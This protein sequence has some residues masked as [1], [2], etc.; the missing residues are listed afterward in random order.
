MVA[1]RVLW[2]LLVRPVGRLVIG[3]WWCIDALYQI[4]ICIALLPLEEC[5]VFYSLVVVRV[6]F[7]ESEVGMERMECCNPAT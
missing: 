2:I 5:R 3:E 1:S 4:F 7:Q 6:N